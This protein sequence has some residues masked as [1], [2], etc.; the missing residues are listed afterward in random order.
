METRKSAGL[1]GCA[2]LALALLSG[3]GSS[4][5]TTIPSTTSIFFAHSVI[6]RNSTTVMAMGYNGFGQLGNGNLSNQTVATVVPNL[7]SMNGFSAGGD[8]TL[9]F[10]FANHSSVFAWGSNYHGQIGSAVATTGTGA[11]SSTPRRI[12]IHGTQPFATTG[13]LVSGVAA[14]AFHSLAV[15]DGTVFGWGYNGFGQL[16]T[17]KALLSDTTVPA[18]VIVDFGITPLNNIQQI[19]AGGG[20]SLALS[21]DGTKV[22]AWGDNSYGQLGSD[23]L[24]SPPPSTGNFFN[25]T[26][27]PVSGIIDP[28]TLLPLKVLQIAAS[29]SN[30]YALD[31]KNRVWAWGYN[32]MGQLGRNPADTTALAPLPIY[33][34]TPLL[35]KKADGTPVVA[36]KIV[37][38]LDHVLALV[39]GGPS[40]TVVAW[41]FNQLGQLGNNALINSFVPVQVSKDGTAA[42]LL[43]GVTDISAF[44]NSSLA[45]VGDL[46]GAWW[47]WGDNGFGQLG[48]PVSTSTIGYLLL[49]T[50]VQGYP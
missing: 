36:T 1:L 12:A 7:G 18:P 10:S 35:V 32:G 3:C 30:S 11:F 34:F 40:G 13:G 22:Y 47:G 9:A 42:N 2:L 15:V 48:N 14:G 38:G 45:R 46:P 17:G 31:E 5:N 6:F 26:P 29:G 39:N 24:S 33:S 4:T 28:D 16:G 43:T 49:P 19:A 20:H 27:T 37:A 23:P 41:G 25:Q 8:H 50:L 21:S 44:G